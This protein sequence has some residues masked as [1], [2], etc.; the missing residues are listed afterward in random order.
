MT[1]LLFFNFSGLSTCNHKLRR[2]ASAYVKLQE[3]DERSWGRGEDPDREDRLGAVEHVDIHRTNTTTAS[4]QSFPTMIDCEEINFHDCLRHIY[5]GHLLKLKRL[6]IRTSWGGLL[7]L[8]KHEGNIH[9]S[10]HPSVTVRKMRGSCRKLPAS[11]KCLICFANLSRVPYNNRTGN[12]CTGQ[13]DCAG[14]WLQM[15][16][17]RNFHQQLK[18]IVNN[19]NVFLHF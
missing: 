15:P 4:A 7:T 16:C 10:H 3:A 12:M 5:V 1:P 2:I 14:L 18:F 9:I 17:P 6:E 8:S 19:M 11:T 13:G